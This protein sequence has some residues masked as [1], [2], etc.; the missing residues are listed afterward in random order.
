VLI[1]PPPS[2]HPTNKRSTVQRACL[3]DPI[4]RLDA[5]DG[6]GAIHLQGDGLAGN[7]DKDLQ[8]QH[9]VEGRLVLDVVVGQGAAIL[10]L[11]A[12]KDQPLLVRGDACTV[13]IL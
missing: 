1:T 11:L 5:V 8:A 7:L 9:Q 2:L 12:G 3:C 10:Q 6:V 4:H 13:G